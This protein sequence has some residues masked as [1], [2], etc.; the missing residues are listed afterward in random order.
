M[1][2]GEEAAIII[3]CI[4]AIVAIAS[5]LSNL[6][7]KRIEVA[8]QAEIAEK[9]TLVEAD[10]NVLAGY[11]KLVDNLQKRIETLNARLDAAYGRIDDLQ[12]ELDRFKQVYATSEI[13]WQ[14]EKKVLENKIIDQ[15][16]RIR[17]LERENTELKTRL[18]RLE[19]GVPS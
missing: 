11:D 13:A 5:A 6:A 3:A 7:A 2:L 16:C 8:K 4:S 1:T 9:K 18:S 15:A 17:D 12:K 14:S 10:A 19:E